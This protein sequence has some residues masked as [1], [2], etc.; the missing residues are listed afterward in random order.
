MRQRAR[1][2]VVGVCACAV[3]GAW[4]LEDYTFEG[5]GFY[6]YSDSY[7]DSTGCHA[8]D[9]I[10]RVDLAT[11]E[12]EQIFGDNSGRYLLEK[13]A[14]NYNGKQFLFSGK[15]IGNG[16]VN[17]DG[18]GYRKLPASMPLVMYPP[19]ND[20]FWSK[21]GYYTVH[22]DELRRYDV[23]TGEYEVVAFPKLL[24]GGVNTP[25]YCYASGDGTRVWTRAGQP[26]IS[27]GAKNY[28]PP[29]SQ[30]Y[31][32]T[33][34]EGEPARMFSRN[35]WGHHETIS[36]EG[37]HMLFQN[38]GHNGIWIVRF[39]DGQHIG[40]VWYE[41]PAFLEPDY[42][43]VCGQPPQGDNLKSITNSNVWIYMYYRP[44]LIGHPELFGADQRCFMQSVYNWRTNERIRVHGPEDGTWMPRCRSLTAV[45]YAGIW[46]GYDLPAPDEEGAYLVAYRKNVTVHTARKTGVMERKVRIGNIDDGA[47]EGVSVEIEPPGAESWLE[48]A[49]LKNS[50]SSATV[51]V[52][53]DPTALTEEHQSADVTVGAQSARNSVSFS[54]HTDNTMLPRPENFVVFHVNTTDSF[55]YA[56]LT[57]DD[58]AEGEDGYYVEFFTTYNWNTE[59]DLIDTLGPDRT[60]YVSPLHEYT[61]ETRDGKYR[62]RA[63]TDDGL[64]S[65]Y[66]DEGG[67]G[68]PPD[69]LVP[70]PPE[71]IL[72]VWQSGDISAGEWNKPVSHGSAGPRRLDISLAGQTLR[73]ERGASRGRGRIEV[74]LPDGR[75]LVQRRFDC[76]DG[77]KIG[78]VLPA[79]ATGIVMIR[80]VDSSGSPTAA[81]ILLTP[82]RR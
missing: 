4:A 3:F 58:V 35:W 16:I 65:P 40:D 7:D 59:W 79:C 6:Y 49:V 71:K 70:P 48:A 31:Y 77:G 55:A 66:S 64:Y 42:T 78:C 53:V 21:L 37:G 25:H 51:T 56:E 1:C 5:Y 28:G 80:I 68:V 75:I 38:F 26:I 8:R 41:K 27:W 29:T 34:D 50:N 36:L 69:S 12:E 17:N 32:F 45:Q 9:G 44:H 81:R 13:C 2:V 22:G 39:R 57:W 18:T 10:W 14:L 23:E 74:V 24:D 76:S 61:N 43:T 33:T 46:K 60:R 73:V 67:F 82:Q 72:P 30:T 11:G 15:S 62:I 54:V 20:I 52:R 63:F 47:L 19:G